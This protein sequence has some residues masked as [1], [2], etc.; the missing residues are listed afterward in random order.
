MSFIFLFI[1]GLG[2]GASSEHNPFIS[3]DLASFEYLAGG[4]KLHS[5]TSPFYSDHLIFTPLDAN[6]D[7]DGLPQSGTG[8]ATLF[9][10]QNAA[11]IIGKHFGPFP[12]SGNKTLLQEQ[13]LFQQLQK[14][15]K[16]PFFV[17]AF[18]K[19]FFERAE[20]TNRW[21]SC[22]FMTR[23]AGIKLNTEE[24]VLNGRAITAE[25]I[26]DYWQRHLNIV[27]PVIE[28]STAAERVLNVA[29]EHDL[30]LMEYYLTDKAG[31]EQN[32]DQAVEVLNRIDGF[33]G[34]LI[35]RMYANTTLLI[36][37]DHGNVEDLSTKSHT[38]NPVPLFV[39]GKHAGM[40][41]GATSIMDITPMILKAINSGMDQ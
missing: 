34:E 3:T 39:Y 1:D 18:P 17:N 38:R 31:H 8:Q 10:G 26:Q 25:I 29:N 15:N 7:V 12:H 4:K 20:R 32:L 23:S 6:L 33:L 35:P 16:R 14:M 21:S 13:S 11:K 40:F 2:V 9:S 30:V 22:T 24:E 36:T 19:P 28:F 27:L 37:S 41:S 5:G